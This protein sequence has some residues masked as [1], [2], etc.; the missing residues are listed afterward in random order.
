MRSSTA[1]KLETNYGKSS[2][3]NREERMAANL[4]PIELT[5]EVRKS[6]LEFQLWFRHQMEDPFQRPTARNH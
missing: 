5:P 1:L 6:I 4:A 2:W 3:T